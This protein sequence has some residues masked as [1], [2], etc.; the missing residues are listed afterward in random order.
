MLPQF[1]GLLI[2]LSVSVVA[3][4]FFARLRRLRVVSQA[5]TP[6][7]LHRPN[8]YQPML[9]LL[10][11]DDLSLVSGDKELSRKLRGERRQIFRG[12]LRCLTKDYGFLLNGIRIAMVNSGTERPD[13]ARALAK[14]KALFALALYRI[15]IRLALHAL[16]LKGVDVSAL[17][18][19]MDS[20]RA[21]VGVLSPAAFAPSAG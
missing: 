5:T 4:Q 12:Y 21:Q 10:S 6:V 16:G 15:E 11:E 1:A 13:L 7:S 8:F 9:R 3:V 2:L 17:V 20:L 14:N 19:A 18:G